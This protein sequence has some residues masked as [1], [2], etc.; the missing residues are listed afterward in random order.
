MC[1]TEMENQIKK[2]EQK[3]EQGDEVYSM[4]NKLSLNT[5]I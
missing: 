4:G 1:K 2:S 5:K 3:N